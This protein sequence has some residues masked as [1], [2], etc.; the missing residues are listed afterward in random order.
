MHTATFTL[1]PRP[2]PAL[3]Y[4]R[5][6]PDNDDDDGSGEGHRRAAT[7][8]RL[9]REDDAR[10]GRLYAR[11]RRA[12]AGR[13]DDNDGDNNDLDGK[14]TAEGWAGVLLWHVARRAAA[15][16]QLLAPRAARWRSPPAPAGAAGEGE[17]AD[18]D[19]GDG[20]EAVRAWGCAASV[21][22]GRLLGAAAAAAE[23]VASCGGGGDGG[24][25]RMPEHV[26]AAVGAVYAAAT[27]SAG[28]AAEA[29]YAAVESGR[30]VDGAGLVALTGAYGCVVGWFFDEEE[31]EGG[32]VALGMWLGVGAAGDA[33]GAGS[34]AI[35]SARRA[36]DG[37][38]SLR[39]LLKEAVTRDENV[40]AEV[41]SVEGLPSEDEV[42]RVLR[43]GGGGGGGEKEPLSETA[44][45]GAPRKG[46]R[47][48]HTD[49]DEARVA[50][51]DEVSA[52][53]G[54]AAAA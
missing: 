2:T 20:D 18:D 4:Q 51:A 35:A 21:R 9:L 17:A 45:K 40:A 22:C 6:S 39:R 31:E 49:G 32:A 38:G 19:D 33:R 7:L 30:G 53:C 43:G 54:A 3:A 8:A 24:E 44:V 12:A 36:G 11:F 14:S 16:R 52:S 5:V 41:R 26:V 1:P 23:A 27:S 10:A 48:F 50:A 42:A 25:E 37:R 29:V 15:D 28:S 34:A 13:G 46:A 47:Q